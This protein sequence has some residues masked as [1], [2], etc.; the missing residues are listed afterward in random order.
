M[1]DGTK[2]RI[3]AVDIDEH[4]ARRIPYLVS[5]GAITIGAAFAECNVGARRGHGGQ[6]ETRGVGAEALNDVQRIDHVALGLRHFLAFSVA[7]ERMDVNL[8]KRHA[9]VF[10]GAPSAGLFYGR[11][12]LVAFHKVAA[13]H[14]HAC[15]PEE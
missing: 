6:R 14:D 2:S 3:H 12:L 1:H 13:E 10:L 15:H 7:H 9:V 5:E 4:E 8:P 11:I